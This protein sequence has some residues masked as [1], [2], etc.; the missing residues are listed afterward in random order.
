M[1][2]Q[3]TEVGDHHVAPDFLGGSDCGAQTAPDPV[4]PRGRGLGRGLTRATLLTVLA[5]ATAAPV[6]AQDRDWDGET[7][8]LWS[9]STNWN[10]N[11]EP[12][13]GATAT[14]DSGGL[15]N[16]PTLN[17]NRSVTAVNVSSGT[18]T[19]D[20]TLTSTVTLSGTGNL[21]INVAGGVVG[22]ISMGSSGTLVNNGT[23]TGNL[24]IA[25]GTTDNAGVVTSATFVSGGLLHL[26]DG[27]N[28]SN[29]AGLSISGGTVSV[30]S[31]ETV[32]FLTLSGG[33]LGG[34][35]ELRVV[36]SFSQLAGVLAIGLTVNAAGD[37]TLE[38][39]TIAGT[40]EGAGATTV[41]SGTTL[42]SGTISGPV[43]V[44]SGA[45]DID[46][47]GSIGGA[48]EIDSL[49][50]FIGGTSGSVVGTLKS[51]GRFTPDGLSIEGDMD[52]AES[53]R[54]F[55][56]LNGLVINGVATLDGE[57]NFDSAGVD[58]T[59]GLVEAEVFRADSIVGDFA[60]FNVA[61]PAG[62]DVGYRIDNA[63]SDLR[64]LITY[65]RV[66]VVPEPSGLALVLL[67]MLAGAGATRRR[68]R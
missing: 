41:Q 53:A 62:F 61:G 17:V 21:T 39:G 6:S 67:A 14:I 19:V 38:G 10:P 40:L 20:A 54:L 33:T 23:I 46:G 3:S 13:V 51:L 68:A 43:T 2:R 12:S 29:S 47:T 60:T 59:S 48:V 1:T 64:Y 30:L 65:T 18:L 44:A 55:G 32:G 16:Q 24:S 28:L 63:G 4:A 42:L 11:S 7:S 56:G 8:T 5:L 37:K 45:L 15:S 27:T 25:N 49:G 9:T 57:L 58:F 66:Q 50:H 31:T 34:S 52:L 22:N 26:N 35:S 36:G